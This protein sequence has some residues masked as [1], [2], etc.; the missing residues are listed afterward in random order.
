MVGMMDHRRD[1]KVADVA[2]TVTSTHAQPVDLAA[3]EEKAVAEVET[4]RES[5]RR[6]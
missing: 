3:E 1:L 6:F 2:A 5:I 4:D